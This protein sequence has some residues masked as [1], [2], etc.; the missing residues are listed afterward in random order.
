MTEHL[1]GNGPSP[2]VATY[3][4]RRTDDG[5]EHDPEVKEFVQ[6]NFYVDDGLVSKPTAEEVVT[7]IKNMQATLASANLRLHKVVS[8]SVN[9]MK[10]FPTENLAKDIRSLDFS[11]DNLPAQRS[12]GVFWNLETDTLT[13]KVSVPDKPFTRRG[14]L[15]VVNSIYN[16]LGL[17]APVLLDG[18]LLLQRLVAMGKKKTSTVCLG[19]DDPLPEDLMSGWQCWKT[20]PS[21]GDCLHNK[22]L[23]PCTVQSNHQGRDTCIF[24]RKLKSH[25]SSCLP[26]SLQSQRRSLCIP[27]VRSGKSSAD[28]PY[29]CPAT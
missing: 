25:W 2:A 16:P 6:R 5:E 12:L 1:F 19:W 8:N 28:Q 18:R 20:A 9:V 14:V 21:F 22:M 17:A 10:A 4:L 23:P 13:Y 29:Q 26:S 3:G 11:Q 24:R 15:S 7:L 27:S